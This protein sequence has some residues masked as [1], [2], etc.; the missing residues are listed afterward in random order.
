MKWIARG[1]ALLL[2]G[3]LFVGT[4]CQPATPQPWVDHAVCYTTS[5]PQP[6]ECQFDLHNPDTA[7]PVHL[8]KWALSISNPQQVEVTPATSGALEAGGEITI[9]AVIHQCPVTI[10]LLDVGQPAKPTLWT[11][12]EL[13]CTTS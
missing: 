5:P 3:W 8:F 4:A 10:H 11:L 2:I 9:E 6:F 7:D 1:S 13:V 12:H